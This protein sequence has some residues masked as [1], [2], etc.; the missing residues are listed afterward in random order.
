MRKKLGSWWS[1]TASFGSAVNRINRRPLL[2]AFKRS[3]PVHCCNSRA[4]LWREVLARDDGPIDY[5]EFV[6]HEGVSLRFF[7]EHQRH[8][9]SRDL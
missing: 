4:D 1:R 5:L 2:E 7:S 3:S 9:S 6:V 8:P